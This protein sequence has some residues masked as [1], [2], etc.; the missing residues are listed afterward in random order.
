MSDSR[1]WPP[2]RKQE[3][4][5]IIFWLLKDACWVMEWRI[6]GLIMILPTM[7]LGLYLVY[8]WRNDLTEL[9]FSSAVCWWILANSVWMIG[10]F[11]DLA[12]RPVA[13]FCFFTGIASLIAF[14]V[15]R[16]WRQRN[17]GG[18]HQP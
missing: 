13:A 16:S 9:A 1:L 6:P 4:L 17:R 11:F 7:G 8:T 2:Q 3:N 5:H 10:E 18:Q 15:L 14:L 12:L